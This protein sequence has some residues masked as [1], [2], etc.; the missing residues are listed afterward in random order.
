MKS[1]LVIL[2]LLAGMATLAQARVFFGFGFGFPVVAPAPVVAYTPPPPIAYAPAPVYPAYYP[3][4][5][6][7]WVAGY[8]Y[9]VG[10]RWL[11][12][13]GYWARR[14]FAGAV[15]VT[16]RYSGGRWYAGYWRR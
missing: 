9:P 6:Y 16:P 5:S 1:K 4:A 12:R 13:A 15:W 3:P 11:W 7:A 10:G 2:T 14:P 8:Y